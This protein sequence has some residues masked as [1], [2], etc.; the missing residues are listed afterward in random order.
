MPRISAAFWVVQTSAVCMMGCMVAM[1]LKGMIR[2]RAQ[3]INFNELDEF[4]KNLACG[5]PDPRAR[6]AGGDMAV[7]FQDIAP[8]AP[9]RI[10]VA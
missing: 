7:R 4:T 9:L 8:F 6:T 2:N 1:K 10:A 5:W 3:K